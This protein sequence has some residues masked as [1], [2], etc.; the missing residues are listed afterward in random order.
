MENEHPKSFYFVPLLSPLD[1]QRELDF[2]EVFPNQNPI[3]VELGAG[4]GSFITKI[5][6]QNLEINFIAIERLLGRLKKIER[7]AKKNELSNLCG[8]RHEISYVLRYLIPECSI[9][10]VHIYFPDPWPK[11]KHERNRLFRPPLT[12]WLARVLKPEGR[13]YIRTDNVPYYEQMNI[14]F[15]GDPEFQKQETPQNL[16]D[17]RTDF[18]DHFNS[19]GIETNY[20][21]FVFKP[22]PKENLRKDG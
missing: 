18:E 17:I 3:E 4:D 13:V 2:K 12:R 5:A 20:A 11:K 21:A 6:S 10:N 7:F 1:I 22:I 15:D 19:K 9:T 16:K 14:V 8:M